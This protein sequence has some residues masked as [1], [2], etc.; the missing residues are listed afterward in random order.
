MP[1]TKHLPRSP[2]YARL[3]YIDEGK[4][5]GA[6]DGKNWTIS[7]LSQGL[8]DATSTRF[9]RPSAELAPY[10]SSYYLIEF[11]LA[12]GDTVTDWLHPE[13]A[14][15]RFSE[16]D[17]W[18]IGDGGQFLALPPIVG[19][20]ATSHTI[21][22]RV[23]GPTRIWGVGILPRGWLRLMDD[24]ANT[25]ANTTIACTARSP[26]AAFA[27][28]REATFSETPD[29]ATEAQ[30]IDHFLLNLLA[31]RAPHEEE[32]RISA[33]HK[34]L[35]DSEINSVGDLAEK[36]GM[37]ARSLERI[38]L[39]AFGFPP[40]LLLRRQRFLRS[41]SEYL[42]DT[43]QAWIKT[44]DEHYVDQAHFVRDFKQFMGMSPSCYAALPHPVLGS[45]TK[46]RAIAAGAPV[47]A[48][49]RP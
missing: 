41:L 43:S 10:I 45:A 4:V 14:N 27:Q 18:Q 39:R 35:F 49:H 26:Y 3:T 25:L 21:P 42:L 8:A 11:A 37:S 46:A 22:F 5:A 31:T 23:D 20:G 44:L 30:R 48:L 15:I 2:V 17:H 13:W 28:L 33:I 12:P 36:M 9:F 16:S 6:T 47:Q 38:S 34:S 1:S 40:K 19:T 7:V 29:A 24:P 32:L